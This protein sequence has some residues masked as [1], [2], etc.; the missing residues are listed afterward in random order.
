MYTSYFEYKEKHCL[1]LHSVCKRLI[2]DFLFF[3]TAMDIGKT[4]H[5][6]KTNRAPICIMPHE[7]RK[8]NVP[9]GKMKPYRKMKPNLRDDWLPEWPNVSFFARSGSLVILSSG[10]ESYSKLAKKFKR[11]A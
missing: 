7:N 8:C 2:A 11:N 5:Q 4:L 3:K 10:I 1:P 6:K 9:R